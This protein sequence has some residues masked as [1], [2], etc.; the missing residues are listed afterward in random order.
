MELFGTEAKIDEKGNRIVSSNNNCWF[1]NLDLS[2]RHEEL[3]LY[4]NI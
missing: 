2:K 3:V 1:T 4:T